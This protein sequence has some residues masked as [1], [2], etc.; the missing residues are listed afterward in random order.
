VQVKLE[1]G[2]TLRVYSAKRWSE[3]CP[4]YRGIPPQSPVYV[5]RKYRQLVFQHVNNHQAGTVGSRET[6][7]SRV[8]SPKPV[9]GIESKCSGRQ[10]RTSNNVNFDDHFESTARVR[11]TNNSSHCFL[12]RPYYYTKFID[13]H[14]NINILFLSLGKPEIKSSDIVSHFHSSTGNGYNR[15]VGCWCSAFT[16]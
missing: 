3:V 14:P 7:M 11:S 4:R 13:Y 10:M 12:L 2:S 16:C 1:Y 9:K 5:P 15:P 6:T 8:S